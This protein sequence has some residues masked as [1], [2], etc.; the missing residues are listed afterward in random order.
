MIAAAGGRIDPSQTAPQIWRFDMTSLGSTQKAIAQ[1]ARLLVN[2]EYTLAFLVSTLP[3][4][5]RYTRSQNMFKETQR[6]QDHA[7]SIAPP[8]AGVLSPAA[9]ALPWPLH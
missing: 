6:D 5:M 2:S 7:N 8:L 1:T 3:E 9:L 4:P